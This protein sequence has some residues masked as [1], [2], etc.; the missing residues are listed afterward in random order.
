MLLLVLLLFLQQ[1]FRHKQHEH[2]IQQTNIIEIRP[3]MA[4]NTIVSIDGPLKGMA[5]LSSL[6]L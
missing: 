2:I 4:N 1:H 6:S 5:S 3:N